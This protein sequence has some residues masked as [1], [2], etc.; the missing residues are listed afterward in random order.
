MTNLLRTTGS[1]VLNM[2]ERT[3]IAL[4]LSIWVIG[5]LAYW[6]N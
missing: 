3:A 5:T 2:S 1:A 6:S 4:C